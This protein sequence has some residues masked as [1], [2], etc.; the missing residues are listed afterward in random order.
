MENEL[1]SN[2]IENKI[3]EDLKKLI[4]S[5]KSGK[6][7]IGNY[8]KTDKDSCIDFAAI[9]EA[10]D[11]LRYFIEEQKKKGIAIEVEEDNISVMCK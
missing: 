11:D 4:D 6:V 3:I 2:E 10:S 7:M 1:I 5:K 9:Y 8:L